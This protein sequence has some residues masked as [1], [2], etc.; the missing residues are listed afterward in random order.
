MGN[1]QGRVKK[2][3]LETVTVQH[4]PGFNPGQWVAVQTT[5]GVKF[6]A[7]IPA[8]SEV[9]QFF[10]ARV[11]PKKTNRFRFSLT[12]NEKGKL[13]RRID[14]EAPSEFEREQV[15]ADGRP[16]SL[17]PFPFRKPLRAHVPWTTWTSPR[18]AEHA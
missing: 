4:K 11:P 9:G 5:E 1:L 3:G 12:R 13:Q 7:Q 15:W 2:G 6:S 10:E 14:V 17:H 18:T 16:H 8:D